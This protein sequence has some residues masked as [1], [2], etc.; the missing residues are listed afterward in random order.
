[1]TV[2]AVILGFGV[3]VEVRSAFLGNRKTDLGTYLRAAWAVRS[4]ADVYQVTDE[5]CWHY[6]YPPVFAILMTPL[7]DAPAGASHDWMLPY[8]VSVAI[9]YLFGVAVSLLAVHWFAT[10]IEESSRLPTRVGS[11]KW[12]YSRTTPFYICIAPIGCTLSRGQVNMIIVALTAGMFLATVRNQRFRSGLWL[13]AAV[14]LKIFPIFL[15]IFPLWRRDLRAVA[16]VAC[17]LFIGFVAIPTGV[18]GVDGAMQVNQK[19]VEAVIKPGLGSG[20]D[21][22]RDKELIEITATDNQSIQAVI[23]N[24]NH[25]NR[26][27]RPTRAGRRTKLAHVFLS[28]LATGMLLAAFG[29]KRDNDAIRNLMLLGGLIDIMAVAS[30]V[31]HTHYFCLALPLVAGLAEQSMATGRQRLGPYPVCLTVL[32]LAGTCFA[33]PMIPVWEG[34]REIG[35]SLYGCVLLWALALVRL[36]KPVE[37]PVAVKQ[38]PVPTRAARSGV[39]DTILSP[40]LN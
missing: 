13:A 30:P 37:M 1:L 22:T 5:N 39:Q 31:S 14:C 34:R 16:G 8:P 18:W 10:A 20:A 32:L 23:H 27:G 6:C 28:L 36:Q 3:L 2:L 21:T 38:P 11:R 40:V 25:W 35:L 9:W 26:E 19:L 12:W 33:L 29:W 24:Y 17:G 15:I 7:A 4:G